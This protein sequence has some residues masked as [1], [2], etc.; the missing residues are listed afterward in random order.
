MIRLRFYS[1]SPS[2]CSTLATQFLKNV[3]PLM[4]A[5]VNYYLRAAFFSDLEKKKKRERLFSNPSPWG[6]LAFLKQDAHVY[7]CL[8]TPI[9]IH[10]RVVHYFT[11]VFQ[12]AERIANPRMGNLFTKPHTAHSTLTPCT[13]TGLS[14][15][16]GL[17]TYTLY[18]NSTMVSWFKGDCAFTAQNQKHIVLERR[19]KVELPE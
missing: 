2:V 9:H 16:V 7:R 17:S 13:R 19:V 10:V 8:P 1:S 12:L 15:I 11:T 14:Q 6:R 5:D 18:Q 3:S 4:G